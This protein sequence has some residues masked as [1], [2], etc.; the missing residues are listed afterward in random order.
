MDSSVWSFTLLPFY[1]VLSQTCIWTSLMCC[2][3]IYFT[4]YLIVTL[5]SRVLV[6]C[7]KRNVLNSLNK[8]EFRLHCCL[9]QMYSLKYV[10][11][12]RPGLCIQVFINMPMDKGCLLYCKHYWI[13][14]QCVDTS[15]VVGW[16]NMHGI[17][18]VRKSY[19]SSYRMFAFQDPA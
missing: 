4:E 3:L 12:M 2:P 14:L 10:S 8:I 17:Q 1:F 11:Q 9:L 6:H 18:C 19:S 13:I 5:L 7:C 16:A 15:L